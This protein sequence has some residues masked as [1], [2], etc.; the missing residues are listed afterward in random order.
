MMRGIVV[1][2]CGSALISQFHNKIGDAC[3][4]L[5]SGKAIWEIEA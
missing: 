3:F 1:F 4:Y 2:P 5:K